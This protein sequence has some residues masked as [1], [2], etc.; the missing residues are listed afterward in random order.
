MNDLPS[1]EV[2]VGLNAGL[3]SSKV[4]Q[5]HTLLPNGKSV[6]SG[7]CTV[8]ITCVFSWKRKS[9]QR[10]RHD[11]VSKKTSGD[12]CQRLSENPVGL[13]VFVLLEAK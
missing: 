12:A 10:S 6:V 3:W 5:H 8:N 1:L 11:F 2:K 4:S 7:N 13:S 9:C